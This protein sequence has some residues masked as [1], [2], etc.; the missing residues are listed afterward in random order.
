MQKEQR[1]YS[2]YT[3]AL[4]QIW[5]RMQEDIRRKKYSEALIEWHLANNALKEVGDYLAKQME[6]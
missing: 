3:T 6:P 5:R 4:P 1:D 2:Y